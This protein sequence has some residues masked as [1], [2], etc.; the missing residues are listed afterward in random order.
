[1]PERTSSEE[2]TWQPP[3]QSRTRRFTLT[4]TRLQVQRPSMAGRDYS[5]RTGRL[6]GAAPRARCFYAFLTRA[7]ATRQDSATNRA[8]GDEHLRDPS[9]AR[10]REDDET[11]D[12]MVDVRRA[13]A[14]RESRRRLTL[15]FPCNGLER[16]LWNTTAPSVAGT[17]SSRR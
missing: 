1:M 15:R 14:G 13:G 11:L 10:R 9:I 8:L 17:P 7:V 2:Q 4:I 16:H 3:N 6:I 12:E 5:I